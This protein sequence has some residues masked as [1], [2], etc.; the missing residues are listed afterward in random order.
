M[1]EFIWVIH[2]RND[3]YELPLF[4]SD[5][6]EEIAKHLG[7]SLPAVRKRIYDKKQNNCKYVVSRIEI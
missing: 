3:K 6:A 2:E 1:K 7:I 4:V 5:N